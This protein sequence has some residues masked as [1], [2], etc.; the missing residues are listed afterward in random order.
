MPAQA[1]HELVLTELL[2]APREKVFRCWTEPALVQR[3]FAPRPGTTPVAEVDVRAGGA[4]NIVMRSPEGQDM[5]NPGVFLEIVPN[6]KIV[7]TDAFSPGWRPAGKPFMV[8][9]ITLEDAP[10]GK[11]KYTARAMHWNEETKRQHE[12]MGFFQGWAICAKQLEEV[13]KSI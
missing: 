3:W 10:G 6:R 11:T 7:F 4:S 2:D 8:A 13:A 5:P 9:E 12:E 1:Q